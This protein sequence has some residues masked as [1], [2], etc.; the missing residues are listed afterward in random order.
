MLTPDVQ[1]IHRYT[2]QEKRSFVAQGRDAIANTESIRR[3]E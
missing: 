3:D 1:P 2:S